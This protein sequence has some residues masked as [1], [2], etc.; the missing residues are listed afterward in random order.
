MTKI[1]YKKDD[2]LLKLTD[3][4]SVCNGKIKA[5]GKISL[6]DNSSIWA[7]DFYCKNCGDIVPIWTPKYNKIITKILN[8]KENK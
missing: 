4:C 5:T 6:M 7:I 8:K 2:S 1:I 3:R